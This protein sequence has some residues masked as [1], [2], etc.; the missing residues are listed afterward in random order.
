LSDSELL[1]QIKKDP[2][3]FRE[4]FRL[5][6]KPIFGYI[7]RRTGNF[8]DTADIA[9]ET[10]LK[11]FKAIPNFVDKGISV[12][13]WLY[14]IAT[15]EVNQYFR[16][17]KKYVKVFERGSMSDPE[18]FDSYLYE[19]RQVLE[20]ELTHHQQFITVLETLKT[21]PVKYQEVIALRYFEGKDNAEIAIILEMK[22]GTLKSL[23][24]RGL[25]KLKIKC[26]PVYDG[27]F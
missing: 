10:F 27:R 8:D 6:Y 18:Q 5:H 9:S 21:L 25:E 1:T 2:S 23:L 11:A 22:E 7:F 17:Q 4:L 26:N 24:S 15:N 19:D 13:I 20:K 12:K 16:Y 14:R 3:A